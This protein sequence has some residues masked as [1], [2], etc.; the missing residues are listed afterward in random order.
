MHFACPRRRWT[1][2]E[3]STDGRPV[4]SVKAT[5][6]RSYLGVSVSSTWHKACARFPATDRQQTTAAE[7]AIPVA[8]VGDNA[9]TPVVT[10]IRDGEAYETDVELGVETGDLV[11]VLRGL[12]SSDMVATAG[13]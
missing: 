6:R 2:K 7:V 5:A 8:A 9:G 10:V 13:G 11:Q 4:H 12:S 3:Q 1:K